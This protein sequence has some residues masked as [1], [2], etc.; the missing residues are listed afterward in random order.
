MAVSS[1]VYESIASRVI[2]IHDVIY[3][4]TRVEN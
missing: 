2:I 1:I 4:W 3:D